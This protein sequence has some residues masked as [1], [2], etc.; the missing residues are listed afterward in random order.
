MEE[1]REE[2]EPVLDGDLAASAA[3]GDFGADSLGDGGS[4]I[5]LTDLL[6]RELAAFEPPE[7]SPPPPNISNMDGIVDP[8]GDLTVLAKKSND[9]EF[10]SEEKSTSE[11]ELSRGS[12]T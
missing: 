12:G 1:E 4:N 6:A 2:E 9:C 10:A 7:S 11:E 5:E 8:R 3:A